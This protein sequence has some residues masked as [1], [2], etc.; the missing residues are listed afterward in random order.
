[1]GI[2]YRSYIGPFLRIPITWKSKIKKV[3]I[4]K[5]GNETS[6]KFNPLTGE[7]HKFEE[8]VF[9]E[10][11]RP[12]P[13]IED[14]TRNDLDDNAFYYASVSE[15]EALFIPNSTSDSILGDV[16]TEWEFEKSL[17]NIDPE[18]EIIKFRVKY[19]KYLEYYEE[20]YGNLKIDFGII[21][22]GS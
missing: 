20:V 6:N 12:Y 16:D 3:L 4:N 11:V 18:E 2:Y 9:T 15:K 17:V 19:K 22:K 7:E 5:N 1:M 10:I 13:D 21:R 8:R 14:E